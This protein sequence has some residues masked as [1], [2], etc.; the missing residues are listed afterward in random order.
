MR[1]L[2]F[3]WILCLLLT[4]L[5]SSTLAVS[6]QT[7]LL[8]APGDL[9][10]S[11][12]GVSDGRQV[13]AHRNDPAGFSQAAIWTGN[14]DSITSL[15]PTGFYESE[16]LAVSGATQVGEGVGNVTGNKEHALLWHSSPES[17]IDLHPTG[18]AESAAF[19][20]SGEHQVGWGTT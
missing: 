16:A 1:A 3:R 13:G 5:S 17:A 20:L 19:G 8:S 15:N 14:A 2:S 11:A 12:Y 4:L 9:F 10:S 18:F 6:Y 7:T